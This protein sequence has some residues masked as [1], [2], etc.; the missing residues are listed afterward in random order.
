[1]AGRKTALAKSQSSSTRTIKRKSTT[2]NQT[3]FADYFRFGESYT[4][5][6]LG[7][8]VVIIASLLVVT[9]LRNRNANSVS[10][11]QETSSIATEKKGSESISTDGEKTYTIQKGDDLWKIAEAQYNN[12]YSWT[13]IAKANN[14][15]NPSVINVGSKLVIPNIKK[16]ADKADVAIV[17]ATAVPTTVQVTPTLT[18]TPSATLT[19]LP[20]KVEPT[21]MAAKPTPIL[22]AQKVIDNG[23]KISGDSYLVVS[24]DYLWDIAERAYGD[25]Y[26]WV[27]IARA[28]K[29]PNPDII[30]PGTKIILPR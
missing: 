24:G 15:S 12:G 9:L 8:I 1:M 22:P 4:S 25:G 3:T 10:I 5:L 6:V 14:L 27:E 2:A 7:I 29:I 16:P 17:A 18:P 28:N 11:T 20:T 26:K 30:Y 21:K 23:P 19:P 13:E